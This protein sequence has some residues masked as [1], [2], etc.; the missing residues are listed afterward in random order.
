MCRSVHSGAYV[1]MTRGF[2]VRVFVYQA[3][4]KIVESAFA[5]EHVASTC[6]FKF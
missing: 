6:C 5:P 2:G 3:K 1:E 4:A